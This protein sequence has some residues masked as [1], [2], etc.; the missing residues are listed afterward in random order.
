MTKA[1]RVQSSCD[2]RGRWNEDA[3]EQAE[4]LINKL[5]GN[6]RVVSTVGDRFD[7]LIVVE[8]S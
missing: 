1:I 6:E 5:P 7:V 2:D 3:L 8:E 4:Q